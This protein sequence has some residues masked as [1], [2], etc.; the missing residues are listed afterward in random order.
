MNLVLLNNTAAHQ[1]VPATTAAAVHLLKIIKTDIGKTFWCGVKNGARG[2]ATVKNISDAGIEID[3]D[4]EKAVPA[5]APAVCLLLGL[6]RPQTLKKVLAT[7][8]ELGLQKIIIFP[9]DKT[10]PSYLQSSIWREGEDEINAIF[11]KAA[12][13]NCSTAVPECLRADSLE[14]ALSFVPVGIVFDIY[15]NGVPANEIDF[16]VPAVF[17]IGSERGWS[18]RER[19][20]FKNRNWRFAHLGERVLRVE[21]AAAFAHALALASIKN[22]RNHQVLQ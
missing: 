10:D 9:T 4:W 20:I 3:I 5:A 16:G 11:C 1:L 21:T 2:L 13:Q 8:A 17:A 22:W 19:E 12:E 15:E 7:S 14:E 6:S 18:S